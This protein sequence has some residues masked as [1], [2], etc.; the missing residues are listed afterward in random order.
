LAKTLAFRLK[1]QVH[2]DAPLWPT[3]G[4]DRVEKR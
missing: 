4:I 1:Q 2:A 3:D